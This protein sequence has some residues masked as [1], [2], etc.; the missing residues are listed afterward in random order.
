M[1]RHVDS[2]PESALRQPDAYNQ[3]L[4]FAVALGKMDYA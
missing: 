2:F 1:H 4:Q 3:T